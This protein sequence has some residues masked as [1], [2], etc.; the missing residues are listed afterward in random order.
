MT[1]KARLEKIAEVIEG[2]E[3]RRMAITEEELREIYALASGKRLCRSPRRS[4]QEK[5]IRAAQDPWLV[6]S[7]EGH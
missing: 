4:R 5:L 1:E 3:T 2:A 7:E 6:A